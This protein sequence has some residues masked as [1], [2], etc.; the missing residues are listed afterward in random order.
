MEKHFLVTVSEQK[1]VLHGVRFVEQFF[2][3]KDNIKL[4]LFYAAPRPAPEWDSGRLH[5]NRSS[6]EQQAREN[7]AVGQEAL[8]A[9]K[10][11][12]LD[13]GFKDAQIQTKFHLRQLSKVRDIIEESSQGGYD[14]VV[15]G[16][17]GLSW[18]AEMM[19]GSVTKELFDHEFD[20]PIWLCRRSDADRKD[21]LLC[22]D[23]SRSSGNVADHVGF[24]LGPDSKHKVT[25]YMVTKKGQK[26]SPGS[27]SIIS[28][29]RKHLLANGFPENLLEVKVV[30]DSDV[31][32]SILKEAEQ[33]GYAAVATGRVGAGKASGKKKNQTGSVTRTLLK[34][35]ERT[36]LWTCY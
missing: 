25:L 15:F 17:R 23:G 32:K 24:I 12:L 21:V 9:A 3:V 2:P 22:L 5:D 10:A 16:R 6:V 13:E 26:E 11:Y 8:E 35:L 36:A 27:Q 4:T 18:L 30:E 7:R 33:G 19:D 31:S 34:E 1:N 29:G 14:A 28:E 20:V